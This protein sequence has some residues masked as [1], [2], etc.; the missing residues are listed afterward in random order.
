[1]KRQI[2]FFDFLPPDGGNPVNKKPPTSTNYHT[3]PR[4][5]GNPGNLMGTTTCSRQS[6]QNTGTN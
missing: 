6:K 4:P 5:A 3:L 1:M 2:N